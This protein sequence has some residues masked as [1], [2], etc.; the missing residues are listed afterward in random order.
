[1]LIEL[2]TADELIS[3]E[4]ISLA[5]VLASFGEEVSLLIT[6]ALVPLLKD[7][8]VRAFGMLQ[9]VDFYDIHGV[10]VHDLSDFDQLSPLLTNG[11]C[12]FDD[13][14]SYDS[15]LKF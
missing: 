3:Y 9:A 6:P 5:F 11:F 8:S 2:Y 7:N 1:M 13:K 4:A 14:L 15:R 10:F 12:V